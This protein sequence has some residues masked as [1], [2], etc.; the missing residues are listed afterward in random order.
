ME[1]IETSASRPMGAY[2]IARGADHRWMDGGDGGRI[3][4][5]WSR[6]N[7]ERDESLSGFKYQRNL[8]VLRV[9]VVRRQTKNP[10]INECG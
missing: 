6:T 3:P 9:Q 7:T 2:G 4:E 5:T 8:D 1:L 10:W